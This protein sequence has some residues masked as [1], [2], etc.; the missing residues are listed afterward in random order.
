MNP[1]VFSAFSHHRL[2]G[3]DANVSAVPDLV[4]EVPHGA[5]L[6]S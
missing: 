4:I 3:R 2:F 5:T 1:S 6:R